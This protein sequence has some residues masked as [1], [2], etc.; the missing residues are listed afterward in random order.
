MTLRKLNIFKYLISK[1]RLVKLLVIIS[2]Y[3]L[4]SSPEPAERTV[5]KNNHTELFDVL[6]QRLIIY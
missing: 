1:T 2:Q 3:L 6:L 4:M 5:I